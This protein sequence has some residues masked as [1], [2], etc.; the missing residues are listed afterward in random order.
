MAVSWL[1]RLIF[2]AVNVLGANLLVISDSHF[3]ASVFETKNDHVLVGHV[4]NTSTVANEFE[5]HQYIVPQK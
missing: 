1:I 5:C 2:L 4:M 3:C